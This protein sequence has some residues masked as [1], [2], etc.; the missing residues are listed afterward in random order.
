MPQLD[1]YLVFAE[2]SQFTILFLGSYFLVYYAVAKLHLGLRTRWAFL[3]D[4]SG[5]SQTYRDE[6]RKATGVWQRS[7]EKAVL[8]LSQL[9]E[10]VDLQ[11][12]LVR[13]QL[14]VLSLQVEAVVPYNDTLW[15]L[16]MVR[17]LLL[18]RVE[19]VE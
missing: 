6:G 8:D 11:Q 7:L 15:E 14:P 10:T 13:S 4:S 3:S 17:S 19:D 18:D 1:I 2:I 12:E 9:H 5:S 16:V